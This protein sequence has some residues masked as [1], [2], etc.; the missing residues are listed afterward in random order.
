MTET[1]ILV[2]ED[3]NIIAL[4]IKD[5]LEKFGYTVADIA[6]NGEQ[7]VKK[8]AELQPD[9]VL[10][11][12]ML[13]GKI[14]GVDAAERIRE[15]SDIPVIY[16]TAYSD[17][18]TLERAK[19]TEPYGYVLKPLEEKELHTTIEIALYKHE[20]ERRLKE[21]QRWLATTLK[22]IGDA[23]IT[24]DTQGII[25][26]MNSVAEALTGWAQEE[27]VGKDSKEIFNVINDQK[28]SPSESPVSQVLRLG[29]TVKMTNNSVLVSKDGKEI[30]IEESAAPIMDDTGKISGVVLVFRDVTARQILEGQLRQSQKL[31][32]IG[33][34]AG[35]IA[36]DFNNMMTAIQVGSDMAMMDLDKSNPAYENLKDIQDIASHASDLTRQLLLFSSRHPM[37]P[38]SVNLNTMIEDLFKMLHRLICEDIEIKMIMAPDLWMIQVDK[39]SIEQVIMNLAVNARDAMLNGG[40][41]TIRTENVVLE[42][43]D[44][45]KR[46]DMKPGKFVLISF[47]DTGSGMD[48]ETIQHIFEPFYSTKSPGMGTGLGLSV[49]YGIV[50]QHKG[51]INVDSEPN[52]GSTFKVYLPALPE[53]LKKKPKKKVRKKKL[54]GSGERILVVDD[55]EKVRKYVETALTRSGYET[56]VVENSEQAL[57]VFEKEGGDFSLVFSDVVLPGKSG[58]ELAEEIVSQKPDVRVL[59]SSG[60]PNFKSRWSIIQEKGFRFIQKPYNLTSLLQTIRE[61]IDQ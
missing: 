39:G 35:G 32:A 52:Q 47:E 9:L 5:R 20:M 51:W 33:T 50:K 12:I 46:T 11:D 7:A 21:S 34:L 54:K 49:V 29:V 4:E 59:L 6:F 56:V 55:E 44:C 13:G 23:V 16:L 25:T 45:E 61:V 37:N 19:A 38:V 36:H 57:D 24:T 15:Y 43:A 10:M 14:D 26:F 3:E 1:R 58:V 40:Q 22:S 60:Y 18:K 53:E 41:L 8:A 30:P 31:E 48:E 27:I 17:D 28:Y 2:V 42:E